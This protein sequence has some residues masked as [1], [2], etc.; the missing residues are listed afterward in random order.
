MESI[1][2]EIKRSLKAQSIL[3]VIS[4][5]RCYKGLNYHG[6]LCFFVFFYLSLVDFYAYKL[7]QAKFNKLRGHLGKQ[8]V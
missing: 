5:L 1:L 7:T 3:Y 6:L 2:R 4:L 8:H